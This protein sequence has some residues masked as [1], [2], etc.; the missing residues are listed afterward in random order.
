[1]RLTAQRI[2]TILKQHGF[3]STPQR[4]ALLKVIASQYD[5][6][7]PETLYNKT[8]LVYP[9]IGLVTIYRTLEML[10]KLNL[11]CRVHSDDGCHNYVMRRPAEHHHHLVCSDCGRAIDFTDCNLS[12]LEQK[13]S[14][15]TGFEIQG[16]LL[17]IYGKCNHC[18]KVVQV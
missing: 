1:M 12:D 11:I 9:S 2:T 15:Q 3:K 16:H 10:T 17:E 8:R 6:F 7:S 13:L 5:S 4:R 18:R 14:M